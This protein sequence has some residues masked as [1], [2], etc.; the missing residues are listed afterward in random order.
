MNEKHELDCSGMVCPLPVARTKKK[1]N[2]MDQGDILEISG[3]F[4]EAAENIK[5]YVEANKGKVIEM[6]TESNNYF[7]KIEKL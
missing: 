4:C 5:R 3:D 2:E 6:K 7:L 1:M